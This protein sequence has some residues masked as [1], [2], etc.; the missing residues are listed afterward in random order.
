VGQEPRYGWGND[1]AA[2]TALIMAQVEKLSQDVEALAKGV[3]RASHSRR[4]A[5]QIKSLLKARRA[6]DQFFDKQ[7]FADP[8]WDILLDAYATKL[9]QKRMSVSDLC[10]AAAVPAA[11]AL[12]WIAALE[13]KGWLQRRDDPLDRRRAWIELTPHGIEA[14]DGYWCAISSYF[15]PI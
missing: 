7:L 4:T 6:R 12:R 14:M 5:Q 15:P 3:C 13:R 11:T 1:A 8:A 9:Q 10:H 2:M